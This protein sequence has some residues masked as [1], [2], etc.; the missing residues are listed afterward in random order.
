M[1]QPTTTY[2]WTT[3]GTYTVNYQVQLPDGTPEQAS[4][5]F[6]VEGPTNVNA[7]T[8]LGNVETFDSNKGWLL[9]CGNPATKVECIKLKAM[10]TIPA[11][12]GGNKGAFQWVQTIDSATYDSVLQSGKTKHCYYPPG[13]D[14]AYPYTSGN[15]SVD[16]PNSGL[17]AKE[18][19]ETETFLAHMYLEWNPNLPGSIPVALGST[20]WSWSGVAANQGGPWALVSS[21]G[22]S[23]SQFQPDSTYP[24]W[25][26]V[27]LGSKSGGHPAC[28]K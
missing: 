2:Y 23:A 12:D 11:Y 24:T 26:A 13:L 16:A 9:I 25:M 15:K 6:N 4:A 18:L 3:Q 10:A 5:Q 20:G 14:T 17:T 21:S 22:P 8:T 28:S 7:Q 27:D 1:N 19:Q